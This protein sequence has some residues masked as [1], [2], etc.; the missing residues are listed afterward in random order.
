MLV[1]G[2]FA[3]N[4]FFGRPALSDFQIVLAPWC[5]KMKFPTSEGTGEVEGD[6]DTA[7]DC[8]VTELRQRRRKD[9]G[10]NAETAL[11]VKS[12]DA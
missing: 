3:Y 11:C 1:D 5:L 10:K 8:Y 12:K 2:H 6:Q 9:N 4:A 7:R